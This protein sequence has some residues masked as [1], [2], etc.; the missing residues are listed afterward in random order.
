MPML[1]DA[2]L[3][4][5]AG[6]GVRI[7]RLSLEKLKKEAKIL[8]KFLK[9]KRSEAVSRLLQHH[10]KETQCELRS[11]KLADAQCTIARKNGLVSWAKLKQLLP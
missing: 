8:L 6:S 1:Q 11:V 4:L 9:L 5:I 7:K 10:P 3:L 2:R